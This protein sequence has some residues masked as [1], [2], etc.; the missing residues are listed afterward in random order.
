MSSSSASRSSAASRSS[1][2]SKA[3][4]S[5]SSSHSSTQAAPPKN[6]D[7]PADKPSSGS[8]SSHKSGSVPSRTGHSSNHNYNAGHS[9]SRQTDSPRGQVRFDNHGKRVHPHSRSIIPH[10]RPGSFYGRDHHYY[11]YRVS[12]LPRY[13]RRRYWG[14]DFYYYNNIWYRHRLGYY[15]VCRPPYGV[16]FDIALYNLELD[17]LN[18]A[19]YT[20]SYHAYTVV[21]SN[22]STINEQNRIIAQNN[23]T[24]A[25]QNAAIA[26]NNATL[27][28]QQ[29][30]AATEQ[31]A[32]EQQYA[33]K[34]EE[35]YLLAAKLGLVQSYADAGVEYY[36]DDGVFFTVDGAKQYRT[37]VPPAGALIKALPDDYEMVT[38]ADGQKY[39]RVDDTIFRMVV[40]DGVPYFEVIGQVQSD[41]VVIK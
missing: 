40:S 9:Y 7:K 20:H 12:Y 13:E 24:I 19:W 36:Y 21:N 4:S 16:L 18:F 23:A 29:A 39:Y 34:A 14:R 33:Q 15:Y 26:Q 2:S 32:Q 28:A 22:Y 8:S 3:S 41:T 37:I 27:A 11:G 5:R 1:S 6:G 25:A 30:Q 38:L 10:D 17:V 31:L 35:S